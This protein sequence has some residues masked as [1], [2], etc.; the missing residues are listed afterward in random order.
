[1]NIKDLIPIREEMPENFVKVPCFLEG[2]L[3]TAFIPEYEKAR[4]S[5]SNLKFKEVED[6]AK[7]SSVLI[8]GLANKGLAPNFRIAVPTDNI[9]ETIFPMIKDKFYSDLNALDVWLTKP[10]YE[11]NKRIWKQANSLVEE[12]LGSI[13]KTPF[14]IQGFCCIS[15]KREK[16]YGII[17]EPSSNFRIIASDKLSLPNGTSFNSLDKDGMIIPDNNGKFQHYILGNG[18]SGVCLYGNGDLGSDDYYGLADSRSNG[19]MVVFGAGGAARKFSAE[20]Y[21]A[22]IMKDYQSKVKKAEEI[23]NEAISTL[24]KI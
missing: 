7:G 13:P 4:K 18:V 5:N 20:D 15:D 12:K 9:Y 8:S 23:V 10:D 21:K 3:L 1:M 6:V 11:G 22:K 24:E 16:E 14:R 19:R 17:L 2:T